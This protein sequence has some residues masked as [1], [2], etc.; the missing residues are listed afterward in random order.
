M[1]YENSGVRNVST[2]YGVRNVGG[3]VGKASDDSI[4][5]MSFDFTAESLIGGFL[6]KMVLPKGAHFLRFILRVDEVFTLTGT[7]PTVIF[8]GTAPAT[9]GIVLSQAE[10]A[11]VGTKIPAS[12]G[13]GTWAVSSATGPLT[14]Q[15]ITKALG[16]TTP[17]VTP[18]AGKATLLAEYIYKTKV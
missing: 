1:P 7:A 5:L 14:A 8:G 3:A 2:Q 10:L 15:T 11:A 9:D 13:T 4:E 6:P 17:V 12:T 18:G 16:G